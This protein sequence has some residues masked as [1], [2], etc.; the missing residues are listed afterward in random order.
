MGLVSTSTL[1]AVADVGSPLVVPITPT[2]LG[3][4]LLLTVVLDEDAVSLTTPA[5]WTLRYTA[6]GNGAGANKARL[7]W[8]YRVNS[9][10][11]PPASVAVSGSCRGY[12]VVSEWG[13]YDAGAPFPVDAS[14]ANW[15]SD[16]ASPLSVRFGVPL[17]PTVDGTMVSLVFAQPSVR[18]YAVVSGGYLVADVQDVGELFV[19]YRPLVTAGSEPDILVGF[20]T[21]A[22]HTVSSL[23]I[24]EGAAGLADPRVRSNVSEDA[25]SLFQATQAIAVELGISEAFPFGS[26]VPAGVL[27]PFREAL[28]PAEVAIRYYPLPTRNQEML[29]TVDGETNLGRMARVYP[30]ALMQPA[31]GIPGES[32]GVVTAQQAIQHVLNSWESAHPW[33]VFEPVPDLRIL[34]PGA[35]SDPRQYYIDNV[36]AGVLTTAA[37]VIPQDGTDR[38]SMRDILDEWLSIFP[39]T[40]VRQT[41]G[42]T[43]ELVPRVGPDAPEAPAV[44]LTWRDLTA[45]SEGD[46]DPRGVINRARVTSQGWGFTDNQALRAPAFVVFAG[47]GGIERSVLNDED[48]LPDAAEEYQPW[49]AIPFNVLVDGGETITVEIDITAFGSWSRTTPSAFTVEGTHSVSVTLAVGQSRE[50]S[51]SLTNTRPIQIVTSRWRI[52]RV[53]SVAIDIQ[54]VTVVGSASNA[55]GTTYLA[56]L[57]EFDIVGT[58]WVRSNESVMGEFGQDGI[59]IPAD[60][61]GDAI[62]NSRAQYGERL[63]QLQSDIFQLTPEQAQ[64]VAQSYVLW[65]INPRTVR[66]VQQSE[67][68]RYPVK[69][70]HIGRYVDLPTGERAVVE[71]RSYSDA[72]APGGGVM[73]SS[74]TATVTEVVID[75]STDWLLLDSGDFLQLDSGELVEVS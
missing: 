40:I 9:G 69:F 64:A 34:E 36:A 10:G 19:A 38:R 67:W 71:N 59:G 2:R 17:T 3:T 4:L 20:S 50:I 39:G 65:N 33:L 24:A 47:N 43:I 1:V 46:P 63:A 41:S 8:F 21:G 62:A 57:L 5:G 15:M 73:T 61:G 51:M 74:F 54:P 6:D 25:G 30:E 31:V 72:F 48:V 23:L 52:A 49:H 60:G 22:I 58:A 7:A 11:V 70:D 28:T 14:G 16:A 26:D 32:G 18:D 12:V 27:R 13:G 37:V 55:F 42:G 44:T 66:D 75:T 45:I 35:V 29:I 56:Y 53:T 68:N